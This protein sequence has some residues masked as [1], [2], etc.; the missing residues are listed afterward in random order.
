[1]LH[2][3]R[4]LV[5]SQF[6]QSETPPRVLA[7]ARKVYTRNAEPEI[8]VRAVPDPDPRSLS[9]IGAQAL[10]LPTRGATMGSEPQFTAQVNSRNGV[11]SIALR[12]ELD[13]AAVPDLERHLAP[14]ES[15]GVSAIMLDLRELT[16][17][18]SVALHSLVR[19]RERAL[20]NGK[21]LILVGARPSARRLFELTCTEYLL[22]DQDAAGVL[23]RFVG[24]ETREAGQSLMAYLNAGA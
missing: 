8:M 3:P 23:N 24:S 19:A 18:D 9:W 7:D 15:D 14:F 1:M 5:V 10:T 22:D 4:C 13:L 21:R 6:G 2:P 12:G 16:F 11:A 20:M 17:M